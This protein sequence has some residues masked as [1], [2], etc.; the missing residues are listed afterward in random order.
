AEG[1]HRPVGG[2]RGGA[3]RGRRRRTSGRFRPAGR[4]RRRAR[5]RAGRPA[6]A[7]RR[8]RRRGRPGPPAPAPAAQPREGAGHRAPGCGEEGQRVPRGHAAVHAQ[9]RPQHEV[10]HPG[11]Q[12]RRH[13]RGRAVGDATAAPRERRRCAG[14]GRRGR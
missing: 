12:Q 2:G 8:G 14:R 6:A 11:G 13:A 10:L 9:L 4:P 5:G 7:A 1:I 3:G